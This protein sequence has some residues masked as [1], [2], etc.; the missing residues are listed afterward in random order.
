[1][2]SEQSGYVTK[3]ALAASQGASGDNY[4]NNRFQH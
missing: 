4:L 1:M 2:M 3:Q